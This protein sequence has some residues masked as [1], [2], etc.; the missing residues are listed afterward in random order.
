MNQF[1]SVGD[2]ALDQFTYTTQDEQGQSKTVLVSLKVAGFDHPLQPS[3]DD[4]SATNRKVLHI[5]A[6]GLLYN[7]VDLDQVGADGDD[8][9]AVFDKPLQDAPA[10]RITT[11]CSIRPT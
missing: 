4:F 8:S 1:L 2:S 7:D 6:P 11:E 9:L 10:T 3:S 5:A